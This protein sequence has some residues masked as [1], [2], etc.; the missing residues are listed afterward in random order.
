[1]SAPGGPQKKGEGQGEGQEEGRAETP[2]EGVQEGNTNLFGDA[3][4]MGELAGH[5]QK[6]RPKGALNR[7]TRDFEKWYYSRGFTDPL[8]KLGAFI[9]ADPVDLWLWIVG[10]MQKVHGKTLGKTMAPGLFSIIREQHAV[11]KELG[12]Y[13]HG[14]KP[15]KIEVQ[16]ER[17]PHLAIILGTDQNELTKRLANEG[18][19]TLGEPLPTLD[20]EVNKNKDLAE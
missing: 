5:R 11:A 1:M 7:H 8:E 13:L 18:A 19:L 2:G 15:I 9:T 4:G 14:K 3:E 16:D 12:P 6:G 17:L 20:D 10:Q